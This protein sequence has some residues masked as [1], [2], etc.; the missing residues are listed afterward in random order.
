MK[1]WAEVIGD[2]VAQSRSPAIHGAWLA[3]ARIDAAYH[4]TQVKPDELADFFASRRDNP[5]WRGC[6][7]TAPLKQA[8]VPFLNH[9]DPAVERIG[10]VNCIVPGTAGLTGYNTDV[11]GVFA[12]LEGVDLRGEIATMIGSGG[13]ARAGFYALTEFGAQVRILARSPDKARALGNVDTFPFDGAYEAMAGAAAIVNASTLGMAQADP[14]P[15]DLLAALDAAAPGAL[16]FDMVYHPEET[17]LLAA[18]RARGLRTVGGLVM[19]E[20]Q[21]RRAFRLFFGG[22]TPSGEAA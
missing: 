18:A 10:A 21:G 2:P 4:A 9:L 6:N 19:L 3:E 13:A 1:P 7:V 22:L 20:G 16:V 5:F 12:A 14:M 8:V 11:D 17:A 15:D